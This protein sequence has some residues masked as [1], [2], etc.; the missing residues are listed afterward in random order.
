MWPPTARDTISNNAHDIPQKP[1]WAKTVFCPSHQHLKLH[2]R[3]NLEFFLLHPDVLSIEEPAEPV[4][5]KVETKGKTHPLFNTEVDQSESDSEC[6]YQL[7]S[8]RESAVSQ[9]GIKEKELC[10]SLEHSL[11]STSSTQDPFTIRR[12]RLSSTDCPPTE[13]QFRCKLVDITFMP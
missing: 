7:C 1:Q 11:F 12:S 6:N 10:W 2:H 5:W 4:S 9:S 3:E 13:Q 8:R